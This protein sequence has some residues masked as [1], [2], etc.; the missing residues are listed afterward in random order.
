MYH[1]L[2]KLLDPFLILYL[3]TAWALV[4]LWCKRT[5]SRRRL[6]LVS[7]PFVGLTLVCMPAVSHLAIGTLEWWYPPSYDRPPEVQA[8]VVLS[9]EM[10]PPDES[11]LEAELGPKSIY[12]CLHAA[13]LYHR[14]DG[15]CPVLV[16]GG[17]VDPSEPGPTL[18]ELMRDLLLK[19]GVAE[20]D[21]IVED[22]SRS[23]YENAVE[24]VSL[25]RERKIETVQLVAD[26]MDLLRAELCFRKQGLD[27]L[28]SGCNYH[29]TQWRWR[30]FN[31][32]PSPGAA[33]GIERVTHE[34]LGIVWYKL[35]E[36]I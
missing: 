25:L 8:I 29:A 20:D 33:K 15:P 11:G 1:F 30:L 6:L 14:G 24:S 35:K 3:L 2:V 4:N 17:K 16:S 22:R 34:W 5:E 19:L 10:H 31:F 36:R 12:R 23:T 26:A 9:S 18:A 32:L 27:V 7:V 28:P 21:L 13:K